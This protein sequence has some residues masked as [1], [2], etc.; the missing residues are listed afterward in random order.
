MNERSGVEAR[1]GIAAIRKQ[2]KVVGSKTL[3]WNDL[4]AEAEK[5]QHMAFDLKNLAAHG[6]TWA[7][8]QGSIK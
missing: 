8:Q 4:W 1:K 2:V 7:E 5:L 6:G 3:T